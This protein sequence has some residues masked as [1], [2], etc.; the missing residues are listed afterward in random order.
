MKKYFQTSVREYVYHINCLSL[1]GKMFDK[2]IGDRFSS[3]PI[4]GGFYEAVMA[5]WLDAMAVIRDDV[6]GGKKWSL[7]QCNI[8]IGEY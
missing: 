2:G 3:V 8:H 5:Q 1:K 7:C 6:Q 4:S